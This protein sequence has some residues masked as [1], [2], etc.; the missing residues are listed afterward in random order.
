[1]K[2]RSLLLLSLFYGFFI[3]CPADG[4]VLFGPSTDWT[5][6]H[7]ECTAE[8]VSEI[9]KRRGMGE[10]WLKCTILRL[11]AIDRDNRKYWK[12]QLVVDGNPR[13]RSF[14]WFRVRTN[15]EVVMDSPSEDWF[16]TS[17]WNDWIGH[18][19][20]LPKTTL[21]DVFLYCREWLCRIEDLDY[22]MWS[23]EKRAW[24][25][26]NGKEFWYIPEGWLRVKENGQ[27]NCDGVGEDD[28][29]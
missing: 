5:G 4:F 28:E 12:V 22:I 10:G 26:S 7:S 21:R 24:Q 11:E 25:V 29:K 6:D 20:Y 23:H 27:Y 16:K 19:D 14:R 2:I 17:Y 15:G 13:Y 18:P 1:M 9:L 3:L 8:R